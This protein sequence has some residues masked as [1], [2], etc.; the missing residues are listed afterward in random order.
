M[1]ALA[2]TLGF[3]TASEAQFIRT[4]GGPLNE[5][6]NQVEILSNGNF[7][8]LGGSNSFSPNGD[9]DIY[10]LEVDP[11]G[12]PV[13]EQTYLNTNNEEGFSFVPNAVG[14]PAGYTISS[15]NN[16]GTNGQDFQL[17]VTNTVGNVIAPSA[18]NMGTNGNEYGRVLRTVNN[19]YR[20]MGYTPQGAGSNDFGLLQVNPPTLL[21]GPI[22]AYGNNANDFPHDM[23]FEPNFGI[24]ICG[25]RRDY[26]PDWN[27][28]VVR[29]EPGTDNL[30]WAVR[31]DEATGTSDELY[32]SIVTAPGPIGLPEITTC[33][34]TTF[35]PDPTVFGNRNFLFT[36]A[37][38]VGGA[39]LFSRI[40]G[41]RGDDIC[42]D[43]IQTNDGGFAMLGTTTSYSG[44]NGDTDFLLIRTDALGNV[45]WARVYGNGGDETLRGTTGGH[46]RELPGGGFAFIG[47]SDSYS[48]GL[49][50]DMIFIV[51]DALGNSN[52]AIECDSAVIVS[53]SPIL[54]VA[55]P[56][57]IETD[58]VVNNTPINP[59]DIPVLS[60]FQLPCVSCFAAID[61]NYVTI[62]T[63]TITADATWPAKV[64]IPEGAVITVDGVMLDITNVDVVLEPCA[65]IEVIN[66]GFL[67]TNNSVYRPCDPLESWAG[68]DIDA[69]STA[70]INECTFKNAQIAL[71]FNSVAGAAFADGNVT[72][73]LFSNNYIGLSVA[74]TDFDE[75]VSGNTFVV[76]DDALLIDFNGRDSCPII[77]LPNATQF[78]GIQGF[79]ADFNR[80]ISQN[81][82]MNSL[83]D[84][85]PEEFYGINLNSSAARISSNN[86]TNM[87]RSIDIGAG[88]DGIVIENNEIEITLDDETD[89]YQIRIA[90]SQNAWISGNVLKNF[91][92]YAFTTLTRAA[93]FSEQSTGINIKANDIDG[94]EIGIHLDVVDNSFVGEN[95]LTNTQ[96][97]GIFLDEASNTDVACNQVNMDFDRPGFNFGIAA[98]QFTPGNFN[99]TLRGNCIMESDFAILTFGAAGSTLPTIVNNYLYNYISFGLWNVGFTGNLGSGL[100]AAT[101]GKN[102]FVSNNIP[103]GAVDIFSSTAMTS[104]GNFGVSTASATVTISGNN[105]F[106]ST[107][108]CGNQ[109]G[110]ISS[111]IGPDETCDGFVNIFP[112]MITGGGSNA[113]SLNS[114]YLTFVGNQ[115]SEK[116]LNYAN[117]VLSMLHRQGST[118]DFETFYNG[119]LQTNTLDVNDANWFKLEHAKLTKDLSEW[120]AALSNLNISNQDEEEHVFL[121]ELEYDLATGNKN[122][123]SLDVMDHIT[124]NEIDDR[125]GYY[126]AIARDF[127]QL[128]EGEHPYI[129]PEVKIDL[130]DY[131]QEGI[132][133]QNNMLDVFPNPTDKGVTVR[134]Y[135]EITEDAS[136]LMHDMSGRLLATYPLQYNAQS[137]ELDMSDMAKG[138]Y[139]LSLN[140]G[141]TVANKIKIVKR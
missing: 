14:L 75:T 31:F 66:G 90:D 55:T 80:D 42:T 76:D 94:F 117:T 13:W 91:N 65:E 86:F 83:E 32:N 10:F 9:Q 78:F 109:I 126:A 50:D 93:I 51:T 77:P 68:I 123:R 8:L 127:L 99:L 82:F 119:V 36:R 102:T 129:F 81:D 40:Y 140:V 88:S 52:S 20:V 7:L 105:L 113:Y 115:S 45:L 26:Q 79:G 1:A 63:T 70:E 118:N 141:T 27:G 17:M 28:Y 3:S 138:V 112:L 46:L 103:A 29:T 128:A 37:D 54:L 137:V 48:A 41:G 84:G 130:P 89:S 15:L 16:I 6:G 4:Y 132:L 124:L 56:I 96:F 104:F 134:F 43:V 47:T 114:D 135:T 139:V 108:S 21:P 23:Q 74:N 39:H 58:D 61:S 98:L 19:R 30:V 101:A 59:V 57:G 133:L 110:T 2:L 25:Y 22:T 71:E 69:G 92:N 100:T 120:S 60:Q 18:Q 73:N 136:L 107:A 72:N 67:R 35:S 95:V 12:I 111:E 24:Y 97:I 53:E 62:P 64:H 131:D 38:A 121:A 33:G 11:N 106:N 116:R 34:F 49:D 44:L 87:F 85:A 5:I 125:R 122:I